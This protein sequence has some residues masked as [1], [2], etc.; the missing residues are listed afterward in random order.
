M[1]RSQVGGTRQPPS[2]EAGRQTRVRRVKEEEAVEAVAPAG[3][4]GSGRGT[5]GQG[6]GTEGG[7]GSGERKDGDSGGGGNSTPTDEDFET[8]AKTNGELARDLSKMRNDLNK[9]VSRSRD[10]QWEVDE[11]KRKRN[12][13]KLEPCSMRTAK[14]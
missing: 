1:E 5:A 3:G 8:V 13:G 2:P 12:R 14:R 4:G 9:E 6:S 10:L 11:E 7:G